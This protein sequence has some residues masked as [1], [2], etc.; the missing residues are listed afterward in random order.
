VTTF[1]PQG[2]GKLAQT[3][4]TLKPEKIC[5]VMMFDEF[6]SRYRKV[7]YGKLKIEAALLRHDMIKRAVLYY[8]L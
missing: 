1:G 2:D 7:L 5:D 4:Q 8:S 6:R 3:G